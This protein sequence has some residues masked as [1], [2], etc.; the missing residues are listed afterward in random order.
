MAKQIS[1]LLS[2]TNKIGSH[3]NAFF[4]IFGKYR[5]SPLKNLTRLLNSLLSK[6][7][8]NILI[9]LDDLYCSFHD[10][11][12]QFKGFS[13]VNLFFLPNRDIILDHKFW[14]H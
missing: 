10:H 4:S 2:E 6:K 7:S 14:L 11:N 5:I 13:K 8:Y 3:E 9:I 12:K 1:N